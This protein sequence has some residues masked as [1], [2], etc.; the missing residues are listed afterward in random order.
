MLKRIIG[1]DYTKTSEAEH[2]LDL[3]GLAEVEVTSEEISHPIESALLL[4]PQSELGW[5]AAEPGLQMVR[6]LFAR[7]QAIKKLYLEFQ[8]FRSAR[9]QQFLLRW[10]SNGGKSYG[11]I[12]RQQYNF[13]PPNTTAEREHYDVDLDNVTNLELTIIPDISGGPARASLTQFR[14]K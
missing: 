1:R 3:D 6:I 7:P 12:V 5:E 11:D 2:W 14:I 9:T 8:E 10:S 13:S 4:Q